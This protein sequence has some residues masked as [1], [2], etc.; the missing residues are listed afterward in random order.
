MRHLGLAAVPLA[1]AGA[2]MAAPGVIDKMAGVYK[3]RFENGAVT[4][5]TFQSENVVEIVKIT[6]STAYIRAEL[7]F[8]NG[9]TCSL[10]GIAD[11]DGDG[12]TYRNKDGSLNQPCHLHVAIKGG[13]LVL[14]DDLT[15]KNY[16]GERGSFTNIGLPAK[17]KRPIRYM[18]RLLKSKEYARALAE[19]QAKK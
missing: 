5:E 7:K 12:L 6:P 3:D 14:N 16:C 9:H 19:R 15:C 4:G 11:V 8:Y 18:V 17:S 13:K 10:T 1:L 2:A